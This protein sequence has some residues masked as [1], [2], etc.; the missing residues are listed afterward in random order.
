M[1]RYVLKPAGDVLP[2]CLLQDAKPSTLPFLPADGE[3]GL[4]VAHLVSGEVVAEVVPSRQ[5]LTEICGAGFPLGRLYFQISKSR[6][7][8]VCPELTPAAFGES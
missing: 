3:T 5:Q 4:V 2:W 1:P 7:Y 6:L 8:R